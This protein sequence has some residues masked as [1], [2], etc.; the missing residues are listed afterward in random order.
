MFDSV[1]VTR[2]ATAPPPR[3]SAPGTSAPGTA[4][5][6]R[7]MRPRLGAGGATAAQVERADVGALAVDAMGLSQGEIG[8]LGREEAEAVVV[9]TERVIAA[10]QAR[11]TLA[12]ET[13]ASRV[14][15][16][17]DTTHA[18]PHGLVASMLA[19]AL[20]CATRTVQRRLVADRRLLAS[21]ESTFQALWD[22]DLERHRAD[23][24]AEAAQCLDPALWTRFEALVLETSVDRVTG[25]VTIVSDAVWRM[26]RSQLARRAR[27]IARSLD[28]GGEERALHESRRQRRVVVGP[29]PHAPGLARWH[30]HLPTDVSN[31][32]YAA[33]D[34]LA[35]SYARSRPGTAMDA[36]RAD[37]LA[38]LVRGNAEVRTVVELVVPVLPGATTPDGP[39]GGPAPGTALGAPVAI[40]SVRTDAPRGSGTGPSVEWF[41]PGGVE[42]PRHGVLAPEAVC[43]LL[44]RPDTL[45]RLARLDPDG[46]IV[47]DPTHYRPSASTRRRVRSRDGTCRFPGCNT[48]ASRTD[49]DHVVAHPDGPT[50][51]PNL[52]CLC[53]THHLF[54]HHGGWSAELARDGT[55]RWTAPDGRVWTTEPQSHRIRDDLHLTDEV[56]PDVAHDLGRGWFP[57]LPPGMSLADLV[58]A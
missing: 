42:L 10:L 19:P 3:T 54:K 4:M 6:G 28:P 32:V 14:E 16:D 26:S 8:R 11:Q 44:S 22:G 25:E 57:G 55:A 30:V 5:P 48:P 45:L 40:T 43:E 13:L 21:A 38:D 36:H 27:A 47:Q 49:V 23:T 37:A 31:E 50:A 15:D 24:V 58:G 56:D 18:D 51:P 41:V 12:M 17:L 34:A 9:A 2:P 35:S 33:V 53:R 7:R 20:H 1:V 46:S 29:D 39:A 52:L